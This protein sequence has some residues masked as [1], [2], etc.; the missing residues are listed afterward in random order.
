MSRQE[1][2]LEVGR[3]WCGQKGWV[4]RNEVLLCESSTKRVLSFPK[5]TKVLYAVFTTEPQP[6]SYTILPRRFE[7][8]RATLREFHGHLLSPA[9]RVLRNMHDAGYGYC[10]IEYEE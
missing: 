8:Y 4:V 1:M 7:R 5:E 3:D 10:H 9:Q 2:K 6:T